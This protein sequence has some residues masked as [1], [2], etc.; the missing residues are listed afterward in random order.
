VESKGL[1]TDAGIPKVMVG[2]EGLGNIEV[3]CKYLVVCVVWVLGGIHCNVPAV[4]TGFIK[5]A[6][7]LREAFRRRVHPLNAERARR[8]HR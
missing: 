7:V 6:L 4:K 5:D 8:E 2:G 3:T 1:K